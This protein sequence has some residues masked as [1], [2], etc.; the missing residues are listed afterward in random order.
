MRKLSLFVAILLGLTSLAFAQQPVAATLN[1]ET[2][3]VI[4]TVR[5]IGNVGGVLDAVQGATAPANALAVGGTY[6]TS[7][8][9]IG[10]GDISQLQ[11]DAKGQLFT[12][13][14]YWGGVAVGAMSAYGT[15]P[16]AVNAVPVNAYVT[17]S[18]TSSPPT[19]S[20][21][22]TYAFSRYHN[23]SAAAGSIKASAGNLYGLVVG[24]NG[25][26]PCY[27]QLFNTAGTPTAGT[28]VIDSYFAQA[29]LT[30]VLAPDVLALENFSTG[31]GYAGATTDGGATTTGCTTSMNI[32]AFYF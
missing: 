28:S 9:T 10:N 15:S 12:D 23:A 17:N 19:P 21:S 30:L 11:I 3:K 26:I 25:T 13:V 31:I 5:L 18:I 8:P 7:L 32:S 6:N 4:G 16:G 22:S 14:N 2:S 24:N 29:G 20:T 27:L 1:A